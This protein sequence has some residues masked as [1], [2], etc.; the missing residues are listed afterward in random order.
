VY[1]A[2]FAD[3]DLAAYFAPPSH[4]TSVTGATIAARLRREGYDW[5]EKLRALSTLALVIHGERDALPAVV[6]RELVELLPRARQILLPN[7]GHMPF[8]EAPERFFT[9]VDEFLAPPSTGP[10]R[11][12]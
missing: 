9:V 6:A 4:S 11:P 1:A 12:R 10:P 5:R 8:W 3:P 2:W 7:A